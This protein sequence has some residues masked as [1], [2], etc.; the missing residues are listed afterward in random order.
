[1][2]DD[3]PQDLRFRFL[4]VN[5]FHVQAPD[6]SR[7]S[8]DGAHERVIW[9]CQAMRGEGP[10]AQLDFVLGLGDYVNGRSIEDL[11][12]ELALFRDLLGELPCRFY[13]VPGNHDIGQREGDPQWET[14]YLEAFGLR[15]A[16]YRFTVDGIH[17]VML[18]NSAT[19]HCDQAVAQTRAAW[20][21]SELESCAGEP[22][23]LCCHVPLLPMRE[24]SVLVKSCGF[25]AWRTQ[26]P[27]CLQLVRENA[28]SILAVLSGH[29]HLTAA[30][31]DASVWHIDI[32]GLASYPSDY[33]LYSVYPDRIEVEVKQLPPE[34]LAPNS[35]IHGRPRHEV[36]YT[37]NKHPTYQQYVMGLDCERRL[38][39]ELAH[40]LA[41]G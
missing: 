11:S 30:V 13:P 18:N 16:N 9:M 32:A 3:N 14:P 2:A 17:F 41:D 24:Q 19:A 23:I 38:T 22:V 21:R 7:F 6:D 40:T 37:D 4:Q 20:L 26:E 12:L 35:S 39:I 1:M 36:N 34:L 31:R 25:P 5:E 27:E 28:D 8:Y 15:A 10:L 33:A 29:L